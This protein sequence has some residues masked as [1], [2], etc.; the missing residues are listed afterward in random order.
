MAQ[1]LAIPPVLHAPAPLQFPSG[2]IWLLPEQEFQE[3]VQSLYVS[4]P[5]ATAGILG[6]VV[7]V[8]PA[9]VVHNVLDTPVDIP[10]VDAAHWTAA[11]L[12]AP[13][14]SQTALAAEISAL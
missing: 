6:P 11:V 8:Q 7:P 2:P 14:A 4:L 3:A 10:C 12:H 13:A 5:L 9:V 1:A